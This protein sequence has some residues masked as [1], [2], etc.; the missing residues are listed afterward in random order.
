MR[1][2]PIP[3]AEVWEGAVR[4]VFAAPGG[5]LT[6]AQIAPVEALIDTSPAT[7]GMTASVRCVLEG[8]DLDQLRAGGTVWLTFW[9]GMIP[10]AATVLPP[11]EPRRM[12]ARSPNTRD[13]PD[14]GHGHRWRRRRP[15]LSLGVDQFVTYDAAADGS[16]V[17]SE[18]ALAQLLRQG[19]F[20][21]VEVGS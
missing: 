19:G 6:H 7:G 16:V 21:P 11:A 5:D 9:G 8:D 3:D 2:T 18:E 17:L 13:C 4:K 12:E 14:V 15:E 1:P 20:E 10:W